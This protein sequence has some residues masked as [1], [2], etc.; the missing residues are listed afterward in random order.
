MRFSL[1]HVLVAGLTAATL[2]VTQSTSAL[3]WSVPGDPSEPAPNPYGTSCSLST[4]GTA[5]EVVP[6][7]QTRTLY[8]VC[9]FSSDTT[10]FASRLGRALYDG[11]F[12]GK[13]ITLME[14]G[15]STN[16]F[17]SGVHTAFNING[18]ITSGPCDGIPQCATFSVEVTRRGGTTFQA[19]PA[20]GYG[21][22]LRLE[23]ATAAGACGVGTCLESHSNTTATAP[24]RPHLMRF[25]APIFG[26]PDPP[27]YY[28]DT[29]Y[30]PETPVFECGT[31]DNPANITISTPRPQ[32]GPVDDYG[33][34]SYGP[35]NIIHVT[36]PAPVSAGQVWA[37]WAD[38]PDTAY[39]ALQDTDDG[40]SQDRWFTRP[41]SL[42]TTAQARNVVFRCQFPE[43][44]EYVYSQW[45]QSPATDGEGQ[46]SVFNYNAEGVGRACARVTVDGLPRRGVVDPIGAD[47]P[48]TVTSPV[49]L[50]ATDIA[51]RYDW[52]G[53]DGD[54]PLTAFDATV[55]ET[56]TIPGLNTDRNFERLSIYCTDASG[57]LN[58]RGGLATNDIVIGSDELFP[59][60]RTI[61][62]C[63]SGSGIGVNP[64]S[65]VPGLVRMVGCVLTVLFVPSQIDA[66]ALRRRISAGSGTWAEPITAVTDGI[67][68]I[69]TVPANCAYAV[70]LPINDGLTMS[71]DSCTGGVATGRDLVYTVSSVSILM[72][73]ALWLKDKAE[74]IM[75]LNAIEASKSQ[76][77]TRA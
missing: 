14:V 10:A 64:S 38:E 32:A 4:T 51:F 65:W 23:A 3:A 31:D 18:G 63:L 76:K 73:G 54:F 55:A 2:I 56:L 26:L 71:F 37:K 19:V 45:V 39:R 17:T 75:T 34:T 7:G 41:P 16:F 28:W 9:T 77:A 8:G 74:Q 20:A 47:V 70:N 50:E 40:E 49:D 33:D 11:A 29:P 52:G 24:G 59:N 30:V 46:W 27:P 42:G 6:M 5:G 62:V 48:F 44:G 53:T 22:N 60:S 1:S 15:T 13:V 67:G 69:T 35:G 36:Y 12:N 21:G 66:S 57:A 43:S 72:F 58:L 25:E 61:D 68:D